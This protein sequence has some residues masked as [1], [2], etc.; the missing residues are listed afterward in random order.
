[1]RIYMEQ[2]L[3]SQYI[4]QFSCG[5]SFKVL[6]L[7][8]EIQFQEFK[9]GRQKILQKQNMFTVVPVPIFCLGSPTPPFQVDIQNGSLKKWMKQK[10]TDK[11]GQ[12]LMRIRFC[13]SQYLGRCIL[14]PT[15]SLSKPGRKQ[16]PPKAE[17]QNTRYS[18][19]KQK[20]NNFKQYLSLFNKKCTSISQFV[21]WV[22]IGSAEVILK[23]ELKWSKKIAQI[24][25]EI[26]F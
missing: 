24:L 22:L 25:V 1:M 4:D 2:K 5:S 14:Y 12:H 19:I 21:A 11:G 17:H 20:L 13:K 10:W 7:L 16:K 9:F 6:F 23:F 8:F 3:L 26:K 15:L 18:T